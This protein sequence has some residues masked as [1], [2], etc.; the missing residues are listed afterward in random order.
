M[1]FRIAD[2]PSSHFFVSRWVE[3]RQGEVM[4]SLNSRFW[5]HML[6]GIGVGLLG[7]SGGIGGKS[8]WAV[9]G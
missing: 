2:I 5:V 1:I 6:G 8:C 7:G 4:P 3:H 9:T